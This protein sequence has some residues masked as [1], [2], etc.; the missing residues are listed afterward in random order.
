MSK[1]TKNQLA[2]KIDWEGGLYEFVNGYG[3]DIVDLPEDTPSEIVIAFRRIK[4]VEQYE[5]IIWDWLPEPG[6]D[7]W[8]DEEE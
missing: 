6:S 7:E 1:Y 5:H 2:N 8:K 4:E 3:L